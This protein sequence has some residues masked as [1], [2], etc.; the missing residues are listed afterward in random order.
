MRVPLSM[1]LKETSQF[2]YLQ[3]REKGDIHTTR[4]PMTT[5]VI[6]HVAL[7]FSRGLPT[8]C[9]HVHCVESRTM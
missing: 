7:L 5:F 4:R 6:S 1:G 9:Q 8:T 3:A 2:L